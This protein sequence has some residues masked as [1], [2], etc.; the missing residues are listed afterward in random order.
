MES[1]GNHGLI[2]AEREIQRAYRAAED[3]ENQQRQTWS[4]FADLHAKDN[5]A[6]WLYEVEGL[7]HRD[8]MISGEER[9][10]LAEC[11]VALWDQVDG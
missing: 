3:E 8:E 2:V 6:K 10:I 7:I 4:F 11:I 9:D 5:P 1:S